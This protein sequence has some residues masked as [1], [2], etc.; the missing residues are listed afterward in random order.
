M[1][2]Q[3]SACMTVHHMHAWCPRGPENG[4]RSRTGVKGIVSCDSTLETELMLSGRAA[5]AHNRGA[6]SPAP[7][8]YLLEGPVARHSLLS[9]KIN[10]VFLPKTLAQLS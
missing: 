6:I 3:V 1:Y 10:S 8:I 5:S 2:V 4:V 9:V 7:P